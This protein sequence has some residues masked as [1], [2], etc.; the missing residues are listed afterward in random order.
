MS[1]CARRQRSDE[2][3]NRKQRDAETAGSHPLDP[4]PT[5]VGL[6]KVVPEK[7]IN[8]YTWQRNLV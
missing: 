2:K 8:R 3:A 6:V 7:K 4:G 1:R 5:D